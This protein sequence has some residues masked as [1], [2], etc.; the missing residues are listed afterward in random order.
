[1][2]KSLDE[3]KDEVWAANKALVLLEG[4]RHRKECTEEE[5]LRWREQPLGTI[6]AL[7]W[8]S[9]VQEVETSRVPIQRTEEA[10]RERMAQSEQEMSTLRGRYRR[11]DIEKV[12]F[13]RMRERKM[14]FIQAL[15]WVLGEQDRYD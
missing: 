11:Q 6:E 14:G 10:V 8:A 3:M 7:K 4:Q 15:R 9:G 13:L 5:F 2:M 12:Q 1:M